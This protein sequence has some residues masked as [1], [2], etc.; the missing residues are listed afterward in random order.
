M[1]TAWE[2]GDP[3]SIG[4][5]E[6]VGQEKEAMDYLR[7]MCAGSQGRRIQ[8]STN[9]DYDKR[10]M[11]KLA[12]GFSHVLIGSV[13]SPSSYAEELRKG[14]WYSEGERQPGIYGQ[15]SLAGQGSFLQETLGVRSGVT[16]SLLP[17][18]QGIILNLNIGQKLNW[19]VL[20][21][22]REDLPTEQLKLSDDGS[23]FVIYK[24]LSQV[25]QITLPD[26]VAHNSGNLPNPELEAIE[27]KRGVHSGYFKN[28]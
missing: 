13:N 18:P 9:L 14:L 24:P 19:V 2:G 26:L 15:G 25:V 27:L 8:F 7:R 16:V 5:V 11:A 22:K 20:C 1:Y 3:A 10:F 28:L 21:V 6:P 23:C 4:F 12:L 17:M